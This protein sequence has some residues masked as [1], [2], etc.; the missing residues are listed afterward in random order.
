MMQR[1][2]HSNESRM[3]KFDPMRTFGPIEV[4]TFQYIIV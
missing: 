1:P 3:L 2:P 4:D